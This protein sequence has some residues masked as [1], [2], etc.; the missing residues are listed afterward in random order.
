MRLL[1]QESKIYVAG[2][3]TLIGAALLRHLRDRGFAKVMGGLGEEPELT[4]A[5][6]VEAF[7][8]TRAPE[9]VFLVA[10]KSGGIGANQQ[11]PAELM[12][13]NLLVQ[14]HVINRVV[15]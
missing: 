13:H 3:E 6:A 7:F 8:K 1:N 11:Y 15:S 9:F 4:E 12:L 2:G 10:G 14:N 5:S